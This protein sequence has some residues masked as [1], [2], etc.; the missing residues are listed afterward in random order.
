M[1][2]STLINT[3]FDAQLSFNWDQD[4]RVAPSIG[5]TECEVQEA[6]DCDLAELDDDASAS[7]EIGAAQPA[8]AFRG[9][10]TPLGRGQGE[11]RIGAVMIRLLKRYG[12][13]DEEIKEG[14]A[15]YALKHKSRLAS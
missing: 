9:E 4:Y 1:T 10:L 3:P 7:I 12:I 11:V 13:T 6:F 15:N 2:A 14:L 5:T 8:T